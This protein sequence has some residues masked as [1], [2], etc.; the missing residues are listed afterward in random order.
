MIFIDVAIDH[1]KWLEEKNIERF[2]KKICKELIPLTDLQKILEKIDRLEVSVLLTCDD[3]IKKMNKKF[4]G[5]NKPTDVL[6]FP[7]LDEKIIR[8][9]GLVKAVSGLKHLCLG[10][11][12]I[13]LETTKKDSLAQKKNF[14]DHLTHLVLHSI[15]HLI[16]HDHEDEKM[17]EIMENSEIKILKKFGIN[18]PYKS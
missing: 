11:I 6:S 7:F 5:K 16:G 17:A 10:D 14:R 9:K 3:E 15:L 8:E 13:S 1:E 18:N 2:I 12:V 4:L